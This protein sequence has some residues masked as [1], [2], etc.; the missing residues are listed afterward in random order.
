[1]KMLKVAPLLVMASCGLFRHGQKSTVK[2]LSLN[3]VTWVC[4]EVGGVAV[5]S[6]KNHPMTLSFRDSNSTVAGFGGCNSFGG[7]Y[8][9][10][11]DTLRFSKIFST[12][13]ACIGGQDLEG[14]LFRNFDELNNYVI[15][16]DTL[17]LKQDGNVLVKYVPLVK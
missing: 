10:N 11:G 6:V 9:L 5:K 12:M 2:D 17:Y 13:K 1:M 14:K 15:A 7:H 16:G 3:T 8:D 4:T